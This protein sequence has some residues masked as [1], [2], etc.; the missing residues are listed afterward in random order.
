MEPRQGN[1]HAKS[2][3]NIDV[4]VALKT[5]LASNHQTSIT[6]KSIPKSKDADHLRHKEMIQM[7][8]ALVLVAVVLVFLF[9]SIAYGSADDKRWAMMLVG[10]IVGYAVRH[11][12]GGSSN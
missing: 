10:V 8:F 12:F 6:I 9:L 11:A 1:D 3:R 7:Y 4:S 5:L 2:R